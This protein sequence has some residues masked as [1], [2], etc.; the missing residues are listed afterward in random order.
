MIALGACRM[1]ELLETEE[2]SPDQAL[3]ALE[4]RIAEVEP[5]VHAL[6]TLCFER[7]RAQAAR[8][9]ALPVL[10]RGALRGLPVPIKD[11]TN[12]AGVRT[13]YGS[14]LFENHVPDTSGIVT[15]TL[16]ANGAIIYA[17]S[18]TPEFGTGGHTFNDVFETTRN[19]HDL[20]KSA[21]GSSGGAAATL[22]SGTAWLAHGSDMAGSLRTPAAF[23]G[24]ASLRP[25]PG[26]IANEPGTAP[27]QHLGQQGPMARSVEDV[28]LLA[29]AMSGLHQGVAFSKPHK[30][31][32]FLSAARNP[33]KPARVAVS[34]DLGLASL[35]P[36]TA[37][38]FDAAIERLEGAG[39]TLTQTHPDLSDADQ[40]FAVQRALLYALNHGDG[41]EQN[42]AMMKPENIW[43]VE[44]GLAVSGAEV[45]S[46][47][48]AQ[49]RVFNNTAKFMQDHDLLICP[50]TAIRPFPVDERYPG[51]SEGV[52]IPRYNE[53]LQIVHL[54]TVTSLPVITIPCLAASDGLPF[55]LQL[56]GKPHGE[57]ALFSNAR[58]IESL[59]AWDTR[60]VDP[61]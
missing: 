42:R 19:P 5:K 2:I 55:G 56:I 48:A 37:D 58:H 10:Q 16:E 33:A 23:C 46:A 7:A 15:E 43:N 27:F 14:R 25:S 18:N 20:S 39:L 28:A 26:L 6:P 31:G 49:A 12:V 60:P 29:D 21:G 57:E 4:E 11:L 1:L 24:V 40:A 9:R 17:K 35:A 30:A 53:W 41:L 8:L 47:L 45:R 13:T 54:I 38:A 61:R 36:E 22:A 59:F 44:K 50:A 51:H 3:D 52:P 32:K 34:P